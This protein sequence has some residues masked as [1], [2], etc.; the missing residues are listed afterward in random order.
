MSDF[1]NGGFIGGQVLAVNNTGHPIR[2]MTAAAWN[3][4]TCE[5]GHARR[6]QHDPG[7][8]RNADQRA[9]HHGC[10]DCACNHFTEVS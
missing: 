4:A 10:D 1:D 2:V 6:P 5:C 3:D 9:I 7:S 8:D